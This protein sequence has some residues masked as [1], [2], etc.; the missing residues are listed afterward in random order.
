MKLLTFITLLFVTITSCNCQ[1]ATTA[2]S[3]LVAENKN[4]SK[5]NQE[6]NVPTMIYEANSRGFFMKIKVENKKIFVSRERDAKDFKIVNEISNE[7]WSEISKL[8]LAV[9]LEKVK[10]LKWPTEKRYYDGAA[11]ANITFINNGV[12]YPANGFD[13]GFPP[14]EIADLVN[15]IV[16]LAENK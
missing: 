9:D 10:D 14:E 13:G 12:E 8:A 11:H 3:N 2:N 16:E 7:D 1:K 15:K 4:N 6:S 5:M